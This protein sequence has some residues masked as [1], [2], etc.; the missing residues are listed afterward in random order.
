MGWLA[1]VGG[2]GGGSGGG[3]GFVCC[4]WLVGWFVVVVTVF[5]LLLKHQKRAIFFLS[6][7][8]SLCQCSHY[9]NKASTLPF[10]WKRVRCFC[11]YIYYYYSLGENATHRKNVRG[12]MH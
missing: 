6:M 10:L 7:H 3:G 12:K 4:C 11:Y 8:T 1:V 2:G 9:R 5:I